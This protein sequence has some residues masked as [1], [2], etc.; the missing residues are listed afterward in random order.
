MKNQI[1]FNHVKA[2]QKRKEKENRGSRGKSDAHIGMDIMEFLE[3]NLH[4]KQ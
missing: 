2:K 1:E 3:R 4:G